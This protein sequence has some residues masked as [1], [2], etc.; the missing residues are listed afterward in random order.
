MHRH[1]SGRL[2]RS[3]GVLVS[4]MR[5]LETTLSC[6]P[7]GELEKVAEGAVGKGVLREMRIE[8]VVR[9]VDLAFDLTFGDVAEGV[10]LMREKFDGVVRGFGNGVVDDAVA[11]EP[12][13]N[14]GC[15]ILNGR[16]PRFELVH[17]LPEASRG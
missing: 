14:E 16:G 5:G 10:N 11:K 4:Q 1:C 9:G 12:S 13:Q 7:A 2:W 3:G 15:A 6:Q 17:G 8:L